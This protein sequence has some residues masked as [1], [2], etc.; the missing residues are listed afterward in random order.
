VLTR[1]DAATLD[2]VLLVALQQTAALLWALLIWPLE[3]WPAEMTRLTAISSSAWL[4][5][6]ASSIVYYALAFWFY[7]IGLKRIPASLAGLFLNLIPIFAVGG[8]YLFLA[9][10]LAAVQWAGAALILVAVMAMLRFQN[11][12]GIPKAENATGVG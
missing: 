7:I 2:P 11:P 4:W 1:R 10:R 12:E 8:A 3:L 5:A 9:E 6:G